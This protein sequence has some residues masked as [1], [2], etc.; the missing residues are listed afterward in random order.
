MKLVSKIAIL[1]LNVTV[2]YLIVPICHILDTHQSCE[3]II[4]LLLCVQPRGVLFVFQWK[5]AL[6]FYFILFLKET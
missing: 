5:T 3:H 4:N 2:S 1:E 6:L